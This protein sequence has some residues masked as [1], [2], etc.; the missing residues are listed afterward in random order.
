M[1]EKR[2]PKLYNITTISSKHRGLRKARLGQEHSQQ[3]GV[4]PTNS[5]ELATRD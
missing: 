2:P 1:F 4:L 5:E 3:D